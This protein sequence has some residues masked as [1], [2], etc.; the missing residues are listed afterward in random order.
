MSSQKVNVRTIVLVLMILVATAF[1]LLSYE[2]KVL[3][4]FTP[5]GAIALFGG[6]YFSEK[7]KAYLVVLVTFILSDM[8]VNSL[9]GLPL[10]SEYTLWY[11]ICFGLIVFF[12]TLIKKINVVNVLLIVCIPVLIHWLVM[13]LPWVTGYPTTPAGYLDSLTAAIPFERNVLFGDIVFGILLF[14]GFELAKNRYAAL[15][16]N[17]ALAL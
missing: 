17:K 8:L 1:R 13:D 3:S 9:Y 15:R 14:G 10:I 6:S 12:G 5:V 2:F 7:W 11:C 4:D 16:P